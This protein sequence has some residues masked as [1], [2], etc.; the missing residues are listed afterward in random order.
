M[1]VIVSNTDTNR[2]VVLY[3]SSPNLELS[4]FSSKSPL[5]VRIQS[6]PVQYKP[7]K[8]NGDVCFNGSYMCG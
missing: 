2:L 7:V 3:S 8:D 6:P 1:S 5:V 4:S